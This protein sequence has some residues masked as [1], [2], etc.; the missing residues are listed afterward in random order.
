[1]SDFLYPE[2]RGPTG[3]PLWQKLI[4]PAIIKIA[5]FLVLIPS[6]SLIDN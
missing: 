5:I 2:C 4:Y 3:T 1:M 6:C